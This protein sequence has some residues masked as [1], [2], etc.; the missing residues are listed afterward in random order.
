M[1]PCGF[2]GVERKGN[3]KKLSS[4]KTAFI[5]FGIMTVASLSGAVSSSLA[6]YAYSTRALLSYT[7]TSINETS[8]LQIGLCSDEKIADMP[9]SVT[10]VKF[11]SDKIDE[12][13]YSNYYYFA[14]SG[15]GMTY[16]IIEK[17][18]SLESKGYATNELEPLTSGSYV[19]GNDQDDFALKQ[20]PNEVVHGHTIA[21]QKKDYLT[22]PLVFRIKTGENED[23]YA[24]DIELW[25]SK[26]I[27]KASSYSDGEVYKAI[28]MFIDRDERNYGANG[29]WDVYSD[30]ATGTTVPAGNL[31]HK[32]YLKTDDNKLYSYD[33]NVWTLL[34][35][36]IRVEA[37]A[38]D[39]DTFDVGEMY[40]N[41]SDNKLYVKTA[42]DFIVNPS[43]LSK[44]KTKVG[45]VL[46]RSGSAYYDYNN[47][48]EILYGEY[49]SAALAL[50]SATGYDGDSEPHDVNGVGN[51]EPTTFVAK[52]CPGYEFYSDLSTPAANALFKYAEYESISSIAPDRDGRDKLTNVDPFNPTSV[53]KTRADDHHLARVNITVYLE[54]W[55]FA[56]VDAE[57]NHS[58]NL[59][60]TF[61]MS[62]I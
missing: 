33:N 34:E 27:A 51:N 59:G 54:G 18:L 20:A 56:V 61:E 46:N 57:M 39:I 13:H 19:A 14:E 30:F 60:L 21:A 45:G 17:Y 12:T 50:K 26:A 41:S 49:D 52:H 28:R 32:Y 47:E 29:D 42:N 62:R 24:D 9:S 2:A 7:G 44:G 37:S 6:W 25:L 38:Q 3:M 5:L 16:D 55:D 11:E 36:G 4:A 1:W 31:S 15:K 40:F 48:G 35:D 23:D 58:F 22:I 53:C 43:A 8:L 10:E